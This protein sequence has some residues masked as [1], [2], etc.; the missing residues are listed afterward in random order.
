MI[1]ALLFP[2]SLF[3]NNLQNIMGFF[4]FE[5]DKEGLEKDPRLFLKY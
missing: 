3:I 2:H 1:S 4:W 5:N